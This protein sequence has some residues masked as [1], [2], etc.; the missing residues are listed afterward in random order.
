MRREST[1][2]REFEQ[3]VLLAVLC[4]VRVGEA[5]GITVY[6]ELMRRT[7]SRVRP[8]A[9]YKTLQRLER[10][11]LL[12]SYVT[13]PIAERGGRRK[14]CYRPTKTAIVALGRAKGNLNNLWAGVGS[15]L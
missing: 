5:Y 13:A 14:R 9:V 2:L 7:D 12:T 15:G 8:S 4:A 1:P 6:D 3:R 10:K 11:S